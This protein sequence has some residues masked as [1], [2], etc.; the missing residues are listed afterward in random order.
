MNDLMKEARAVFAETLQAID[1]RRAV[2]L[3]IALED[4]RLRLGEAS[5]PRSEI[6][7]VVVIAV[8]KAA[9]AMYEA[10]AGSLDPWIPVRAV[11]ISPEPARTMLA[12]PRSSTVH[13]RGSH[14]YPDEQSRAAAAAVLRILETV[15]VRSA[16]LFL[17]SGGASS[18]MECPIDPNIP[19]QDMADFHRSLVASGLPIARMN[20]LRKHFSAVKGGRLANAAAKARL[21]STLLVSDVPSGQADA[22]GSGPSLPDTTTLQDVRDTFSE[23]AGALPSRVVEFFASP[24]CI[25]TPKPKD[26][27]FQRA[28]WSVILSSD[29][30]AQAAAASARARGFRVFV[31]NACDEWDYRDAARYLLDRSREISRMRD[32]TCLISVGEVSVALSASP[33]TGGRNQQFVLFCAAELARRSQSATVLSAGSDGIDGVSSAAGAI[34]DERTIEKAEALGLDID[35]ALAGFNASPALESLEL[36]VVTGRTGNNLRDIRYLYAEPRT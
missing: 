19:D 34:C 20:A 26:P 23:I 11:V 17:V 6:D 21:Q 29:H 4:N 32:R 5:V 25:E 13:L 33:G 14:P 31:D 30:L 7:E 15:H 3:A 8:G 22:V 1:V 18:M 36:L 28:H 35:A 10:A 9:V 16:V 12:G 24:A 27:A 2:E